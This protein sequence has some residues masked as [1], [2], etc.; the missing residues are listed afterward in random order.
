MGTPSTHNLAGIYTQQGEVED[1]IA[2]YQQSLDLKE[3]I[4]NV[5]GKATSYLN[6]NF[7][8]ERLR[9]LLLISFTMLFLNV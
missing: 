1:A 6:H 9:L 3:K 4:G 2:L 8:N 7:S 5:Q